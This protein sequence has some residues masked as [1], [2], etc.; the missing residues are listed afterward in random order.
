M[1]QPRVARSM[2]ELQ[3]YLTETVERSR[4]A[5]EEI[6]ISQ[7]ETWALREGALSHS[8]NGFFHITGFVHR[9]TGREELVMYQPQGALTGLAV[10]RRGDS[11][12][13]L[14]QARIEPGNTGIGNYGPTVQSTPANYLAVHGGKTT[15]CLDLFLSDDPTARFR[16]DEI[17]PKAGV[18]RPKGL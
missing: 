12:Y 18:W 9:R 7:Q 3:G 8:S 17:G 14:L 2:S 5:I 10:Y 1:Q 6:K 16:N 13:L 11:M 4:F 15:T